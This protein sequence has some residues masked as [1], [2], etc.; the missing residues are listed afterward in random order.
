MIVFLLLLL[1]LPSSSCQRKKKTHSH[2][3]TSTSLAPAPSVS[4]PGGLRVHKETLPVTSP[5]S[6]FLTY[7]KKNTC[8]LGFEVEK[9]KCYPKLLSALES[10][11]RHAGTLSSTVCSIAGKTEITHCIHYSCFTS[12]RLQ[13]LAQRGEGESQER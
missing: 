13:L 11:L 6:F 12:G 9:W 3:H 7:L 10:A 4:I 1:F 2:K 8:F 5:K